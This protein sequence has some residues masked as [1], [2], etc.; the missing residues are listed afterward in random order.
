MHQSFCLPVFL[1]MNRANGKRTRLEL[2]HV[3][4]WKF[5]LSSCICVSMTTLWVSSV[6]LLHT[7]IDFP[8]EMTLN[9][10]LTT[11]GV[12]ADY[13]EKVELTPVALQ[14]TKDIFVI[15]GKVSEVESAFLNIH[16]CRNWYY[17]QPFIWTSAENICICLHLGTSFWSC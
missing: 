4:F 2:V 1:D 9:Y 5:L 16:L 7:S 6:R 13:P 15:D 17:R 11:G 8:I 3:W 12:I 14:G 10:G